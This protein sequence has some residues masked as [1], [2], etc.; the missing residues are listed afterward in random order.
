MNSSHLSKAVIE[1]VVVMHRITEKKLI[2]SSYC[3]KYKRMNETTT[4]ALHISLAYIETHFNVIRI[5]AEEFAH[6]KASMFVLLKND[7]I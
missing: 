6:N 2:Y 3:N 4:E 5:Y 7:S 1:K